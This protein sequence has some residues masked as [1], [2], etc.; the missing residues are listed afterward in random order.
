MKAKSHTDQTAEHA[1]SNAYQ[2]IPL[3][4]A[5]LEHCDL[6]QQAYV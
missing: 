4:G 6:Q 2:T 3:P 5:L 1:P